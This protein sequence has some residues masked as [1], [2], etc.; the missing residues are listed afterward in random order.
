[1]GRPHGNL[2]FQPLFRKVALGRGTV[3]A[4]FAGRQ[5]RFGA[6]GNVRGEQGQGIEV[7]HGLN[8]HDKDS[9]RER[10]RGAVEGFKA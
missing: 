3:D 4:P 6:P 7:F 8:E 9:C 10:K 5:W 2:H 1:M